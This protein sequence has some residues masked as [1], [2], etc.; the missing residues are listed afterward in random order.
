MPPYNAH[1]RREHPTVHD[2]HRS[3]VTPAVTGIN[4]PFDDA[5]TTDVE[6]S[7]P[8]GHQPQFY[9]LPNIAAS[10]LDDAIEPPATSSLDHVW[11][12]IRQDKSKRMAKEKPKVQSLEEVTQEL[13]HQEYQP[14]LHIPV[15]ESHNGSAPKSLK[16]QKS[17]SNFR[18]STDGRSMVATFDMPPEVAKQDIHISFQRNRLIVTWTYAEIVEWKEA[19]VMNRERT[20][21]YYNRTLPLPEGTRFE[22]IHAQMTSRGLILRYPNMRCFR[23]DARSRSG[24][25]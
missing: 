22:E 19:G 23:V 9:T 21:K 1:H 2:K 13:L 3:P 12:S 18:E 6:S 16:K 4:Y 7:L 5:S 11:N 10:R 25:S 15:V 14:P 20:E 17:I 8:R 24:D